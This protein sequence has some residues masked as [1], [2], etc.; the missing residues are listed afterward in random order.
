MLRVFN[1]VEFEELVH[2]VVEACLLIPRS[3]GTDHDLFVTCNE[4]ELAQANKY[5]HV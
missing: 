3:S 2:L 1:L 5:A 4:D